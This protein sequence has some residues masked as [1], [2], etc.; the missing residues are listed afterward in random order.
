MISKTA[1][2]FLIASIL[3]ILPA[4]IVGSRPASAQ[5]YT[6]C[7]TDDEHG[8]EEH[9]YVIVCGTVEAWAQNTCQVRGSPEPGKYTLEKIGDSPGGK[10]G[11]ALF[12]LTCKRTERTPASR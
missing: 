4:S 10:C 2:S 7:E 9:Q 8:C 5:T 1:L 3:G 11:H 6:V 12:R